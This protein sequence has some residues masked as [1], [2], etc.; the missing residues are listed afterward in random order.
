MTTHLFDPFDGCLSLVLQ[1]SLSCIIRDAIAACINP[2]A[3]PM[4]DPYSHPMPFWP[5]LQ[6]RAFWAR[7]LYRRR[8]VCAYAGRTIKGSTCASRQDLHSH[9]WVHWAALNGSR[10]GSRAK[11]PVQQLCVWNERSG[12]ATPLTPARLPSQVSTVWQLPG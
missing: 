4:P 2:T 6:Y 3:L 7:F 5:R 10:A 9:V 12:S 8:F 1:P 11:W